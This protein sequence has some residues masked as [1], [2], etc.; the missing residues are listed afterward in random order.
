MKAQPPVWRLGRFVVKEVRSDLFQ[1]SCYS[2][3]GYRIDRNRN[4][5]LDLS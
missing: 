1:S 2:S 5:S 4:G 3:L